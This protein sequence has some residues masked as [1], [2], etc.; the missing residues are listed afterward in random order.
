MGKGEV[1]KGGQIH[2]EGDQASGVLD[3]VF[4]LN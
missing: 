4:L 3:L 1:G 2:V